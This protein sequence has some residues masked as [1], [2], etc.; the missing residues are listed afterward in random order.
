M[1]ISGIII[2]IIV[3]MLIKDNNHFIVKEKKENSITMQETQKQ[4]T[5]ALR[6]HTAVQKHIKKGKK[7]L[8]I[9]LCKSRKSLDIC[10]IKTTF[11]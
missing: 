7:F 1:Q 5:F 8:M 2:I 3:I 11:Q 6:S 4:P 10:K 9:G